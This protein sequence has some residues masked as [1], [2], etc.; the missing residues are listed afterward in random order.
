M[1][2]L[3]ACFLGEEGRGGIILSIILQN[4]LEAKDPTFE[5][6]LSYSKQDQTW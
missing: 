4:N 6:N 5:Q 3:F 2:Y 1:E